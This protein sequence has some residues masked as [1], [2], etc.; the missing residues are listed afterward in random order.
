M[1]VLSFQQQG[2]FLS[3]PIVPTSP[4]HKQRWKNILKVLA[5]CQELSSK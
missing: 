4:Q 1:V 5:E 2:F 3:F